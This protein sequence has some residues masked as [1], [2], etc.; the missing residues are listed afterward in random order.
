[1]IAMAQISI[2]YPEK[3]LQYRIKRESQP[4]RK[5]Q[6]ATLCNDYELM[7]NKKK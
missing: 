1:M 2:N 5:N 6:A 3:S 7:E 4:R